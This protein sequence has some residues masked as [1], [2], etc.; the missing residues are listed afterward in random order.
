MVGNKTLVRI[1]RTNPYLFRFLVSQVIHRKSPALAVFSHFI[2]VSRTATA[3]DRGT[4]KALMVVFQQLN[5][6][7]QAIVGWIVKTSAVIIYKPFGAPIN[8]V[9]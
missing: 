3:H 9:N 8:Q 6:P 1:L 7:S 2:A 4:F 5:V